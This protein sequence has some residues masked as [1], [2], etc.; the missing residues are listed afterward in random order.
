MINDSDYLYVSLLTSLRSVVTHIV[1]RGFTVWF[2]REGGKHK[3]FGIRCP[4]GDSFET[5]DPS[6]F[7]ELTQNRDTSNDLILEKLQTSAEELEIIGPTA[8]DV[9]RLFPSQVPGL[10]AALGHQDGRF[11]YELKVPLR[12]SEEHPYGIGFD[13]S[14]QVGVGFETPETDMDMMREAMPGKMP[15][16]SPGGGGMG[17]RG[18]RGGRMGGDRGPGGRSN[19]MPEPLDL[20]AKVELA[21]PD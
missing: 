17:G 21:S 15:G 6:Q 20:W 2:D 14:A 18:M 5:G 8:D 11:V 4:I 7:R 1:A 10:E 19:D 9:I 16:G 3:S 13:E 12:L